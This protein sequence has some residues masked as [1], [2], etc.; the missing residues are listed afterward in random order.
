MSTRAAASS[1]WPSTWAATTSPSDRCSSARSDCPATSSTTRAPRRR[2]SPHSPRQA[3]GDLAYLSL[4][5]GISAGIVLDG[6]RPQRRQRPRRRD[7]PRD[8]PTPGRPLRMRPG[9]LR[10]AHRRGAGNGALATQ[11]V[12]A[13]TVTARRSAAVTT[14]TDVFRAAAA[15]DH[16]RRRS[17]QR[18]SPTGLRARSGAWCSPLGVTHI[19]IGG[20]IAA[21][22]DALL[23]RGARRHRS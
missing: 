20:G 11:A 13:G 19:V 4:G 10:R 2:G 22:G 21:A 16:A 17:W 12:S 18:L 7:R 8:R 6:R 9:R 14:A 23:R 15:G 3:G 5:T 1:A